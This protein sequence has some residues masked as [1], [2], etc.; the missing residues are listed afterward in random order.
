VVIDRS[1]LLFDA[2]TAALDAELVQDVLGTMKQLASEGWTMVVVTHEI[3][4]ARDVADHVVL[5][6][7][8]HVVEEGSAKQMFE[9]STHPRTQAFLQRIEQ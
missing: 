7:D 5:I 8:G 3:K 6:E 2:P 1:L 4:F 9:V